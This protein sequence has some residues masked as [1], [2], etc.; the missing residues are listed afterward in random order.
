MKKKKSV[1]DKYLL[2]LLREASLIK[3]GHRCFICGNMNI[4]ELD[5]HH[6]IKR[7]HKILRYDWRNTVPVCRFGCHSKIDSIM[8][9]RLLE[10]L[11]PLDMIHLREYENMTFKDYCRNYEITENEF[12]SMMKNQLKSII[13]NYDDF[14]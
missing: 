8:G 4:K 5:I 13:Q 7:K 10:E 11:R 14:I 6:I 12:L 3:H 9:I 1:S 2:K